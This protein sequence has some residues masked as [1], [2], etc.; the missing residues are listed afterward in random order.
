[1]VGQEEFDY[2]YQHEEEV[3]S[4]PYEIQCEEVTEHQ[5]QG[6]VIIECVD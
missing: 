3:D 5:S 2:R 4:E 1:M 6:H